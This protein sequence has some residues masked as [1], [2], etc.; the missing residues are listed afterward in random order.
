MTREE[1]K[2]FLEEKIKKSGRID[3]LPYA[4]KK[5]YKKELECL[6]E[7]TKY[8]D[9]TVRLT[10]RIYHIINNLNCSPKCL[11]EKNKKYRSFTKGYFKSCG[12]KKC[13]DKYVGL[14]NIGRLVSDETRAKISKNNEIYWSKKENILKHSELMQIVCKNPERNEKISLA[15]TGRK[16]SDETKRKQSIAQIKSGHTKKLWE[17]NYDEM[18]EK[19]IKKAIEA[20]R[21]V[22]AKEK[23]KKTNLK[24]Y[25]VENTFQLPDAKRKQKE[26]YINNGVEI[27]KKKEQ[28]NLERYGVINPFLVY[29]GYSKVSQEL[30]NLLNERRPS[31]TYF[32]AELNKEYYLNNGHNFYL[33]D[34]I[35]L[36][37]KKIIEFNGDFWHANPE[38]YKVEEKIKYPNEVERLVEDVWKSDEEKINFAK[39]KGFD[40]LVIWESEFNHDKE[41]TI[42]KCLEF[43]NGTN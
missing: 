25:G 21:T 18:Y 26:A 34:F 35:D 42:Q 12:D 19:S 33:Y 1:L 5:V 10:E 16:T 11:C 32:Y 2:I 13:S 36:S 6:V 39:S 28:T 31:E 27:Q 37:S 7:Y 22:E 8:L 38:K 14:G 4:L 30:F 20:A 9:L 43:L 41:G 24:K 17:E 15:L 29:P 23:K 40:V 3:G